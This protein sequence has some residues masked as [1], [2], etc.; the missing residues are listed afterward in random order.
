MNRVALS[1]RMRT[2]LRTAQTKA[3]SRFKIGGR[4]RTLQ[5]ITLH[6]PSAEQPECRYCGHT[7][8]DVTARICDACAGELGDLL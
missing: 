7:G 2:N 3:N 6:A 8:D 4:E 1:P 5:R